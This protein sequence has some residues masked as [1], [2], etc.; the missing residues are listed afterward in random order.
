MSSFHKLALLGAAGATIVVSILFT[1]SLAGNA[2]SEFNVVPVQFA[3]PTHRCA[4]QQAAPRAE[5]DPGCPGRP[6]APQ[7]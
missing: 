1:A 5:S 3:N 2:S 4:E 7:P 6:S